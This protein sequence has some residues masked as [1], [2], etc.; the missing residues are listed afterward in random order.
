MVERGPWKGRGVDELVT[1][2]IQFVPFFVRES[3]EEPAD[4]DEVE[5]MPPCPVE[6]YVVDFEDAVWRDEIG[7]WWVEIHAMNRNYHLLANA[8]PHVDTIF[9]FLLW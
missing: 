5:F 9:L 8:S 4:V 6:C 1:L 7:W 2:L 3:G